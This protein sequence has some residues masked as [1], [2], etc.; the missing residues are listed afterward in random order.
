[1][2]WKQVI[3]AFRMNSIT[4]WLLKVQFPKGYQAIAKEA[5]T[6]LFC[7]VELL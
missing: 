2:K 6:E 1:M 3:K 7:F 4:A 5:A